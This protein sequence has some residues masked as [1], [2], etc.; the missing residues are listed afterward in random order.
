M[1]QDIRNVIMA[2]IGGRGVMVAALTLARAALKRYKHAVWLP[3][4]TT[5]MRGGP[6]EATVAFSASPIAS[7]LVWHPQAV[8]IMEASQLAQ[9]VSRVAPG[10]IIVTE[11]EGL[12]DGVGRQDL[13]VLELPALSRAVELTGD[14][15]ASNLI[16]LGAYIQSTAVLPVELI[17]QELRERFEGRGE[18]LSRNMSA[19]EEGLKMA[20]E[21]TGV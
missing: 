7:P 19:F 1:D 4:M 15:Q 13:K 12:K 11:K 6:C 20:K 3:S 5:A 18:V 14:S 9:F 21:L 8:V 17:E 2:G 10:G 16:L